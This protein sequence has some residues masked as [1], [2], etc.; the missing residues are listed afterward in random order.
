MSR[1]A[2]YQLSNQPLLAGAGPSKGSKLEIE[3]FFNS[4]QIHELKLQ[5]CDIGR[6]L[7]QRA[8]VDGNGGNIAIRV[9]KDIALCTPLS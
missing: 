5:I 3:V 1:E 8:Y 2:V 7:W 9:G 4:P 6:R